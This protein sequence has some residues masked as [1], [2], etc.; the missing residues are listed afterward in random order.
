MVITFTSEKAWAHLRDK[1]FVYT[2]RKNRRKAFEKLERTGR[3]L[4]GVIDWTS[5]GR[6]K[7]KISDVTIHEVGEMTPSGLVIYVEW[8]GFG[9]WQKWFDEIQRLNN[10][11]YS[12]TQKGWLYKVTLY[13]RD[14]PS[15]ESPTSKPKVK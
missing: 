8:S 4:V 10:F 7:P 11:N 12:I 2:Y 1:G 14:Q 5:R 15:T 6:G 13:D 9:S 3:V